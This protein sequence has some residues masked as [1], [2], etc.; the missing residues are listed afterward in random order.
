[1]AGLALADC[2]ELRG[3]AIEQ[4]VTWSTGASPGASAGQPVRLRFALKN[5]DLFSFRFVG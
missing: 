4:E 1:M 2:E 3:D 5:A